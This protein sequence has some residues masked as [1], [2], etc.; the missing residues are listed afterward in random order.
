MVLKGILAATI[1]PQNWTKIPR[2]INDVNQ[3]VITDLSLNQTID[4]ACI[5]GKVGENTR[6]LAVGEDMMKVNSLSRMIPD[7]EAIKHLIAEMDNSN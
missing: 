6:M 5:A 3:A 2:L 1:K 7:L 4:L